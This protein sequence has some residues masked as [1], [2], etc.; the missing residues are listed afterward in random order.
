MSEHQKRRFMATTA[1]ALLALALMLPAAHAKPIGPRV[2]GPEPASGFR[3]S[4]ATVPPTPLP[5]QA[6]RSN[7]GHSPQ[8]PTAIT[9]RGGVQVMPGGGDD[10]NIPASGLVGFGG[11]I[12]IGG[13]ALAAARATRARR[14]ALP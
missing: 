6:T 2:T 11:A 9:P 4:L 8:A 10:V 7:D 13:L 1:L 14:P 3:H 12:V 5:D